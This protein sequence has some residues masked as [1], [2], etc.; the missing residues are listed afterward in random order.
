MKNLL[1]IFMLLFVTVPALAQV[2]L[3][4]GSAEQLI[5]QQEIRQLLDDFLAEESDRLPRVELALTSVVLPKDFKVPQGHVEHQVI[6][7][8][9]GVIGSRRMTLLTRVDNRVVSNQSIRVELKAMA[10]VAIVT[11]NLQRG[12]T[13][14]NSNVILQQMDVTRLKQPIYNLDD[15]FGKQLKRSL[16]LGQP[17][18]LKQIDFPPT[19]KRGER[20]EIQAQR[21]ALILTTAGEA[22]QDGLIDETIKVM[23][24][25]SKRVILCRVLGPGLVR[26]EF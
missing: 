2:S 17:L 3:A 25:G 10:E 23:N 4:A 11:A 24:V 18:A 13:L 12:E 21:G 6:P 8:K 26:V 22:R 15:I 9:P 5:D 1:I 7:A 16:R 20:V 14:D 19:I